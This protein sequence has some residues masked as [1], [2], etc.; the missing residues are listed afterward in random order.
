[1]DNG[2]SYGLNFLLALDQFFNSLLRGSCDETLSS[3]TY[4]MA[5]IKGGNWA[6]FERLVNAI[7]WRDVVG[8]QRH[9]ELSYLVEMVGG[10]MP[11]AMRRKLLL[12]S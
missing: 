7:F 1:M 5:R 6:R 8:R 11:K 2:Y 10:H 12:E 4:R 3:R 9:C